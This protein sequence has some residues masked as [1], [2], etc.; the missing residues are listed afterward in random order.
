MRGGRGIG[1]NA[2]V[3]RDGGA[4]TRL[5]GPPRP[6]L[7]NHCG[8]CGRSRLGAECSAG[9]CQELELAS[10]QSPA[11]NLTQRMIVDAANVYWINEDSVAPTGTVTTSIRRVSKKG[12]AVQTIVASEQGRISGFAL[13][14]NQI[15]WANNLSL[16]LGDLTVGPR[17]LAA[18][19]VTGITSVGSSGDS[20]YW[21]LI[22]N[23]I[24]RRPTA[25]SAATPESISNQTTAQSIQFMRVLGTC[26]Y[27]E[28]GSPTLGGA[29]IRRVCV[30]GTGGDD[31][32]RTMSSTI[33][34]F[35]ADSS[36]VYFELGS[37]TISRLPLTPG[38]TETSV[39]QSTSFKTGLALDDTFIYFVETANDA[40]WRVPKSGGGQA[41]IFANPVARG[42]QPD[43]VVTD[44]AAVYWMDDGRIFKKAR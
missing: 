1:P 40:I 15:F 24:F 19:N 26:V 18:T 28:G 35:D 4:R 5:H 38:Q 42:A 33:E 16:L 17:I 34:G 43:S 37:G 12:G 23:S 9:V 14:G 7:T 44:N 32:F 11:F 31:L 6:L 36:G 29:V 3:A 20:V 22:D 8:Q 41:T 39:L 30:G 13:T 2:N 21:G 10:N 27:Y 25:V